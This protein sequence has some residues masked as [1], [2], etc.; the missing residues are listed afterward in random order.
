MN[1][2]RWRRLKRLI[3]RHH[4]LGASQFD[5][6]HLE[7]NIRDRQ[8]ERCNYKLKLMEGIE[9]SVLWG[10]R[11]ANLANPQKIIFIKLN[12]VN[13]SVNCFVALKLFQCIL[14]CWIDAFTEM[15]VL[16]C[17]ALSVLVLC[18]TL[19]ISS[20]LDDCELNKSWQKKYKT[21]FRW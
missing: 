9:V 8:A 3:N 5:Q 7:I 1:A 10:E 17:L 12:Y 6:Q 13:D 15:P 18:L 19:Q 20:C 21:V 11:P 16:R 2:G 14:L 4:L